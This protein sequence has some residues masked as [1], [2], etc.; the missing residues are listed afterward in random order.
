MN[1]IGFKSLFSKALIFCIK[2]VDSCLEACKYLYTNFKFVEQTVDITYYYGSM[3]WCDIN[4]I[5]CDFPKDINWYGVISSYKNDNYNIIVK[6]YNTTKNKYYHWISKIVFLQNGRWLNEAHKY[7]IKHFHDDNDIKQSLEMSKTILNDM[8]MY[9]I[10]ND[11]IYMMRLHNNI[12]VKKMNDNMDVFTISDIVKSEASLL[13]IEYTHE[14]MKQPI[15]FELDNEYFIIGNELFLPTF[16]KYILE[17]QSKK[18][19]F[20]ENYKIN[21]MD[22][23]LNII[24]LTYH[25]YMKINKNSFEI[26]DTK[27]DAKVVAKDTNQ[28]E[29]TNEE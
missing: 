25:K 2:A 12:I 18:Y 6:K 21:I 29:E 4:N 16:V 23:D 7:N 17:H 15:S 26:I 5:R 1:T 13:S 11:S 14:D 8:K 27:N 22:S 28:V 10:V 24:E 9:G 3:I 19:V 20:D